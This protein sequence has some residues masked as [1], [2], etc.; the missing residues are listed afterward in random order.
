MGI[1]PICAPWNA[2]SYFRKVGDG[3]IVYAY[4]ANDPVNLV[5]PSGLGAEQKRANNSSFFEVGPVIP[6]NNDAI[7]IVLTDDSRSIDG[8]LALLSLSGAGSFYQG[9]RT[10]VTGTKFIPKNRGGRRNSGQRLRWI[11]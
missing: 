10:A 1:D 5:D 2:G 11:A 8:P 9:L 7:F 3:L 6:P 4:V